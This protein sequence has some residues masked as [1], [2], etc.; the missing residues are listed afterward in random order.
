M[1]IF[2]S[3]NRHYIHSYIG[4]ITVGKLV[5]LPPHNHNKHTPALWLLVYVCAGLHRFVQRLVFPPHNK[6][7]ETIQVSSLNHS[8]QPEKET[9]GKQEKGKDERAEKR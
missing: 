6:K 7:L 4:H 5:P 1:I 9:K 8:T 2:C 3:H